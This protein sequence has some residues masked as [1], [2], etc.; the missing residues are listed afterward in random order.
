MHV[1]IR[2]LTRCDRRREKPLEV[3]NN[4]FEDEQA[5][6]SATQ[7]EGEGGNGQ[8]D[9]H[10]VENRASVCNFP[11]DTLRHIDSL[12]LLVNLNINSRSLHYLTSVPQE[13]QQT[14]YAQTHQD[15]TRS[16]EGETI[17]LD[18]LQHNT[19]VHKQAEED[20]KE[21]KDVRLG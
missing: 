10:L 9:E 13:R 11:N 14:E 5:V 3:E 17:A 8:N 4:H 16:Q 12:H 6:E 2:I 21:E 19:D 18:T 20:A 1:A 15:K 7:K